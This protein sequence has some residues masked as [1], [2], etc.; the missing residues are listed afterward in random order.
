ML[1][2]YMFMTRRYE[3]KCGRARA[4]HPTCLYIP[5]PGGLAT[6][7][8]N[9]PGD[10]C[11]WLAA[12]NLHMWLCLFVCL[13]YNKLATCPICLCMCLWYELTSAWVKVVTYT[14]TTACLNRPMFDILN[15]PMFDIW[16]RF[17]RPFQG[18]YFSI[19]YWFYSAYIMLLIWIFC[20][21]KK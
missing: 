14:T 8:H 10:V 2:L 6:C 12:A 16:S 18:L 20:S 13:W 19:K 5:P 4:V 3:E 15:R 1:K 17:N 21:Q 9:L 11:D 7:H